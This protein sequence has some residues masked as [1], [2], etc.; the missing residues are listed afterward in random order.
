MFT[1]RTIKGMMF[2][3]DF[4]ITFSGNTSCYAIHDKLYDIF[5]ITDFSFCEREKCKHYDSCKE[6]GYCEPD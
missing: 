5:D 3:H 1:Q 6:K 2:G 4:S